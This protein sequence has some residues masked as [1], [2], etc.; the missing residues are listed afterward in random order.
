MPT[1]GT[2]NAVVASEVSQLEHHPIFVSQG[3]LRVYV[4]IQRLNR[5]DGFEF[6][7]KRKKAWFKRA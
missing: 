1:E 5:F 4:S 6:S 3:S 7:E 2:E